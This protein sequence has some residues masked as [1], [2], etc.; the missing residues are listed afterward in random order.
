MAAAI[1][2]AA[3]ES[4][5]ALHDRVEVIRRQLRITMFACGASDIAALKNTPLVQF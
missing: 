1:L 5:Q 4:P 2:Q 3:A